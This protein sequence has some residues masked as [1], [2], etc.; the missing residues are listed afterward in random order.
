[1]QIVHVRGVENLAPDLIRPRAN[2]LLVRPVEEQFLVGPRPSAEL[3][4][5]RGKTMLRD[6]DQGTGD[7]QRVGP[8][9]RFVEIC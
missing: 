2:R 8:T 4:P 7:A 1:M 6:Q 9:I 3:F 5:E